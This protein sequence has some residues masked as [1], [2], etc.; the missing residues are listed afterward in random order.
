MKAAAIISLTLAACAA[1]SPAPA[2]QPSAPQTPAAAPSA[3]A[4]AP[5]GGSPTAAYDMAALGYHADDDPRTVSA[6]KRKC[7]DPADGSELVGQDLGEWQ[8]SGWANTEGQSLTLAGLRGRVVV[9]RFW[10]VGCPYCEETMPALQKLSE[11]LRD[12]PVTF[13]GAFHAKPESSEQD[14]ERPLEAI[15]EWKISFPLA[16]DRQWRTLRSWWLERGHRHASSV[17]FV[18]GKD[19]RVVHV[20]PGPIYFPSVDPADAE[21]NRDY[22]ALRDAVLRAARQ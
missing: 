22:L 11:E 6:R 17:T 10:T 16:I 19:G 12:Q 15:R 20:H 4:S 1:P 13:V 3:S 2:P 8:L 5:A 21:A 18:L 9:V 14:L 7:G